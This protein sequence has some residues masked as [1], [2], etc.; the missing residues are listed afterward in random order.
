M[1]SQKFQQIEESRSSVLGS[2]SA[3]Q[4]KTNQMVRWANRFFSG[5]RQRFQSSRWDKKM[6]KGIVS[7]EVY[8][9]IATTMVPDLASDILRSTQNAISVLKRVVEQKTITPISPREALDEIRAIVHEWP[10]VEFREGILSVKT[11]NITLKDDDEEVFLGSFWMKIELVNP[12][13]SLRIE[14]IDSIPSENGYYH[15]H[16]SGCYL[17]IGEGGL[18]S[19]DAL[20]Q[21]RLEDYFRIIEAVLQTYNP[22][23][24][25]EELR[26][27]YDPSH[28]DQ[29][30]CI[31]CEEWESD[32]SSSYCDGCQNSYCENCFGGGRC[33]SCGEL[34]C[35]ECSDVCRSCENTL[36]A[37]CNGACQEC[38]GSVC[39]NCLSS[40]SVCEESFCYSCA[41][42]CCAYCGD[43]MCVNCTATCEC[44]GDNHCNT[45]VDE[46]CS[47]CDKDIC[48]ECQMTC[49]ECNKMLCVTCKDNKCMDCGNPMCE[50][51]IEGHNCLTTRV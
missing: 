22:L 4:I 18:L 10:D 44:C 21:G 2:L 24:P 39:E 49:D 9:K 1:L 31:A 45:C 33:A 41:S 28:E 11:K 27:W 36:C 26:E 6:H 17:C 12:I 14:A 51:C 29:S 37:N 34:R 32:E 35:G 8:E 43:K 3:A 40:C 38:G 7:A 48:K 23:S 5:T 15:P 20:C 16:V 30:L 47:G 25:H 50:T 13:S 46:K 19:Q 42:E